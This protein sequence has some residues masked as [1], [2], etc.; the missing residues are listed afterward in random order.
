M[1]YSF[2][3]LVEISTNIMFTK[4]ITCRPSGFTIHT[5]PSGNSPSGNSPSGTVFALRNNLKRII[6]LDPVGLVPVDPPR[7]MWCCLFVC[8]WC[9]AVRLCALLMMLSDCLPW[10]CCL[11][12]WPS[13]DAVWLSALLMML[14]DCLPLWIT[15]IRPS[16][17]TG[18]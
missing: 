13:Y 18:H 3:L 14:S 12:V 5:S 17:L 2:K 9:V 1:T 16:W 10:W 6:R 15:L 11:I 4:F 8:P 7:W